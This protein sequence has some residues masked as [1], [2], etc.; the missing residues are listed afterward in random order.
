M[1]LLLSFLAGRF[2][3]AFLLL[4]IIT[5]HEL[6]HLLFA[7]LL[8]I[9]ASE[10]KIYCFGGITKYNTLLNTNIN[11]EI[12]ILIGGPIFQLILIYIIYNL[13]LYI[14]YSTYIEFM[15]INK[16]LLTFNLLPLTS[17]DGGK[18]VNLLLNKFLPFKTS[19]TISIIAS[20]LTL[21]L[22]FKIFNV[23]LSILVFLFIIKE[24]Y[25][26]IT[27][28]NYYF[29]KM[30]LERYLD[31]ITFKKSIF[32]KNIKNIKRDKNFEIYYNNKILNEK[33]Y[34]SLYFNHKPL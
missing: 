15:N 34:L 4:F 18:L 21:P 17:L 19:F 11:K 25:L 13:K 33:E 5:F 32:I 23:Y 1:F 7:S 30:L 16:I 20:I 10:I 12:F 22:I 2:E 26:E 6:G 31:K 29:N 14:N 27:N 24:I 3:T 9:N 8:K 28:Y